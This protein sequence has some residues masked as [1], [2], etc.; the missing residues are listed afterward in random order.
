MIMEFFNFTALC[1]ERR[2]GEVI[3]YVNNKMAYL[4][5]LR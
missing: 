4:K 2:V 3:R 1:S 5:K